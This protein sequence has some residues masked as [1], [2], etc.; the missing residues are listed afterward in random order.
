MNEHAI[1]GNLQAAGVAGT[2]PLTQSFIIGG[3]CLNLAV[4]PPQ[5]PQNKMDRGKH[6]RQSS[7]FA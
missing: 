1:K 2:V 4:L 7:D 5:E 6:F 3:L